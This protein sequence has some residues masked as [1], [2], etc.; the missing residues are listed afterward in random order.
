MTHEPLDRS[1]APEVHAVGELT[2]PPMERI[3]LPGGVRLMIYDKC[4][5]AVNCITAVRTGG[6]AEASSAAVAAMYARTI[7]EGSASYS[8]RDIADILDF[9]GSWMNASCMSHYVIQ[10][11]FSLNSRMGQVLPGI[12]DSV[13]HPVFP[14][15]A[16][17][18]QAH[19]LAQQ[20]R[21]NREKVRFLAQDQ[22]SRMLMGDSHPLAR[23]LEPDDALGVTP[24]MLND[25]FHRY[26]HP[27]SLTVYVAGQITD[28]VRRMIADAFSLASEPGP[29][30]SPLIT[31]FSPEPGGSVAV[32]DRP[33]SKQCAIV[34]SA[35]APHRTHPDY[36]PLHIAVMALGGYFGSRLMQ[37]VREDKGLTYGISAGL[38]GYPDGSGIQIITECDNAYAESVIAEIRTELRRMAT[39]PPRGDELRRLCQSAS[40]QQLEVLDTPFSIASYHTVMQCS[41]IPDGYFEAK[42]K[43]I[44]NLTPDTIAGMAARYLDDELFTVSAAGCRRLMKI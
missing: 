19:A 18:V 23:T 5:Y 38:L 31:S 32:I 15:E 35:P 22:A 3:D 17:S 14:A 37:N 2:L 24:R 29:V 33:D 10:K 11:F 42:Q 13:L 8:V 41:A 39:D 16:V 36:V 21:I 12:A 1:V 43:A 9:N 28:D 27:E 30:P 6:T 44:M 7:Q 26:S 40:A 20:T 4:D 25:F 34:M